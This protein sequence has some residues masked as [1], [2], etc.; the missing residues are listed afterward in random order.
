MCKF[1][2]DRVLRYDANV[3][4]ESFVQ[5]EGYVFADY[6]WWQGDCHSSRCPS[7]LLQAVCGEDLEESLLSLSRHDGASA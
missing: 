1:V 2:P 3:R 6:A 4:L 7:G 5:R